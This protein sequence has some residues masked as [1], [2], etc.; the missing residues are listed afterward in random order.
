[1]ID[2]IEREFVRGVLYTV[3]EVWSIPTDEGELGWIVLRTQIRLL[4]RH[5]V[6]AVATQATGDI[7][8]DVFIEVQADVV[9]TGKRHLILNDFLLAIA[10][11]AYPY[12]NKA[13]T[14]VQFP[15]NQERGHVQ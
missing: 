14:V 5:D 12:Y 7:G 10:P 2:R 15:L 9:P 3:K 13:S 11:S 8:I 6:D 1:M 4:C